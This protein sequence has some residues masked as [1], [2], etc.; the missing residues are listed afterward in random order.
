M[1]CMATK[2]WKLKRNDKF[3]KA[4]IN[5]EKEQELVINVSNVGGGEYKWSWSVFDDDEERIAGNDTLDTKSK[6]FSGARKYMRN[7]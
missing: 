2:D 1:E 6:A 3:Q 4:W 5:K 7:N